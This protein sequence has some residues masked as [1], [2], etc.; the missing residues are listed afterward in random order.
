MQ[1]IKSLLFFTLSIWFSNSQ[2]SHFS[3][4]LNKKVKK[5]MPSNIWLRQTKN[6]SFLK[7]MRQDNYKKHCTVCVATTFNSDIRDLIKHKFGVR[8]KPNGI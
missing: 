6:V 1:H 4:T 8:F 5:W 2:S 3:L 7:K